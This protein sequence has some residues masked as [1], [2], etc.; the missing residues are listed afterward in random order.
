MMWYYF[1]NNKMHTENFFSWQTNYFFF[2]QELFISIYNASL[3]QLQKQAWSSI[4]K[5]QVMN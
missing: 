1:T 2:S 5:M 3:N 4:I